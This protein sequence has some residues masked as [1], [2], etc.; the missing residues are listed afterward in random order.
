M[1]SVLAII[2]K[3]VFEQM[4]R[5]QKVAPGVVV[6]TDR[7]TSN[8]PRLDALKQG[9]DM[10]LVTVRPPN[11]AL[12]LVAVLESPKPA[13]GAWKAAPNA[14]PITDISA[15]KGRLTF[16]SGAGI[17]ARPGALGMSLQTPR[18]L[19]D[20]DIA[21]LRGAAGGAPATTAP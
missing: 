8:N 6:A 15:V 16:D 11:E 2:S 13:G 20:A 5:G 4:T 21:L 19:T 10:F 3:A 18:V 7:Y 12:W 17:Q 14:F 1:P 9:G